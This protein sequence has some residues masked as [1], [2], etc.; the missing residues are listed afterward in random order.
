MSIDIKAIE[1]SPMF[2]LSLGSKELFHSNF[3]YWLWKA[4][5]DAFWKIMESF[6]IRISDKESLDV[7]REWEHL[8]LSIV[9]L[10]EKKKI[11]DVIAVI[12]NKVKSIPRK[13]QLEEYR[14]KINKIDKVNGCK[15]ILLTLA[16]PDFEDVDGWD[17]C[18]YEQYKEIVIGIITD[19]SIIHNEYSRSIIT[20][21]CNMIDSLVSFKNEWLCNDFSN[22]KYWEIIDDYSYNE[23]RINDLR[24]KIIYSKIFSVLKEKLQCHNPITGGYTTK[25]IFEKDYALAIGYGMTNASGFAEVKV[26]INEDYL[27]GIQIQGKQ[28]RHFVEFSDNSNIKKYERD[29]LQELFDNN[30]TFT[31]HNKR[32]CSYRNDGKEM[33]FQYVYRKI[34]DNETVN[35]VIKV[36][37]AD[38][39]FLIDKYQ[40]KHSFNNHIK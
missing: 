1:K 25:D 22:M 13:E 37:V 40:K 28:Y 10:S 35:N 11:D 39:E 24:H 8:D 34:E 38:V 29:E 19:K 2:Q 6:G 15:K 30:R 32:I 36:I 14:N 27:L 26:K 3:L 7:K 33:K 31:I 17:K 18:T 12:E 16:E 21:Y 5:E 4:E 20:D 23:L 9:H